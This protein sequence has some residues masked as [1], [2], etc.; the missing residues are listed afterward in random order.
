MR[1]PTVLSMTWEDLVFLHWPVPPEA[2]RPLVP[3]PLPIDT[4]DGSAWLSIVAF[5]MRRF[6]PLTVPLPGDR[7]AF[8]Q[9]NVRTYAT[10]AGRPGIVLLDVSVGH[11]LVAA[12]TRL[13]L[14]LPYRHADVRIEGL[15]GATVFSSIRSGAVP[16]ELRAR[17]R[18]TGPAQPP[19][20]DSLD[21]FLASRLSLYSTDHAGSVLRTDIGHAPWPLQSAIADI[22]TNTHG[23]ALGIPLARAPAVVRFARRLDVTGRLPVRIR[24]R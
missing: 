12:A 8:G 7:M 10:V 15:D 1:S 16:A 4:R 3:R 18:P 22:D 17:W 5:R 6:R 9:L 2:L 19:A 20:P 11:R 21:E 23:D 24:T 14:R 13:T